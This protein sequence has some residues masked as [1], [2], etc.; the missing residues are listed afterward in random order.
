MKTSIVDVAKAAGVSH[1]TVSRVINNRAGVSPSAEKRV[2]EAMAAMGYVPPL[3]RPGRK[4]GGAPGLS[5][6][7]IGLVMIGQRA[8]FADAPVAARVF[9]EAEALVT[10]IGCNLIVCQASKGKRLPPKIEAGEVDGLLLYGAAPERGMRALLSRHP[11]VWLMSQ[12]AKRGYWGDRVGPDNDAVGRLAAEHLI[13]REGRHLAQLT[14]SGTHL[15][16]AARSEAFVET[17]ELM[18]ASVVSIPLEGHV[19]D[20]DQIDPDYVDEV[21]DQLLALEPRPTGLFVPRDRITVVVSHA[22][23]A[24]GC[25]LDDMMLISCDNDPVLGGL[26]A[27]PPTIDIRADLIALRAV[28]QLQW[29]MQHRNESSRVSVTVDPALIAGRRSRADRERG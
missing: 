14:F 15:G 27:A 12:R 28:E 6:G 5:T 9:H 29:R 24:R 13:G 2:R 4:P 3:R 18:G 17:A 19:D 10:A 7:N 25:D 11:S 26:E 1:S 16:Y 8:T 22:L 23:R 21:V 20:N